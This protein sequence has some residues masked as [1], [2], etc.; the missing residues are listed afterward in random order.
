MPVT[1][2]VR[3][4]GA[5]A[6][7]S[8]QENSNAMMPTSLT[9]RID[10]LPL[11]VLAPPIT[12]RGDIALAIRN[13][14]P[15][16]PVSPRAQAD[17]I[18]ADHD[19]IYE[20]QASSGPQHRR[21]MSSK[22]LT[23]FN[24]NDDEAVMVVA[25]APAMRPAETAKGTAKH[26]RVTTSQRAPSSHA[27][28]GA[29][30][31]F[32]TSAIAVDKRPSLTRKPRH[33]ATRKRMMLSTDNAKMAREST[34]QSSTSLSSATSKSKRASNVTP[35]EGGRYDTPSAG[36]QKSP[37]R[38]RSKL[39]K[40]DPY[41][42]P[43]E[44]SQS[45]VSHGGGNQP[46][47]GLVSLVQAIP[48]PKQTTGR[49]R[50]TRHAG[51]LARPA[52]GRVELLTQTRRRQAVKDILT[53]KNFAQWNPH[54]SEEQTLALT[55]QD[56]PIWPE[57]QPVFHPYAAPKPLLGHG[58]K[59]IDGVKFAVHRLTYA[60][61]HNKIIAKDD[62]SHLMDCGILSGRNINPLHLAQESNDDNQ[63][64]KGHHKLMRIHGQ[65]LTDACFGIHADARCRRWNKAGIPQPAIDQ[66]DALSEA[67]RRKGAR[68]LE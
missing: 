29:S 21:R 62:V 25:V 2:R 14:T 5:D 6:D 45:E 51:P 42:E 53:A 47:A 67:E 37:T 15:A 36:M 46:R 50:K 3:G 63:V 26:I 13:A 52:G 44:R 38:R 7:I 18:K 24:G 68:A 56:L 23:S 49:A 66:L 54:L 27:L 28:V 20:S 31:L 48:T 30:G 43:Y 35:V 57:D 33:A 4:P 60:T 11:A 12:A 32:G 55:R 61:H 19:S 34:S 64:R 22:R 17:P 39:R 16:A 1:S 41:V 40:A 8:N 58:Q 9:S 65:V 59:R 10:R